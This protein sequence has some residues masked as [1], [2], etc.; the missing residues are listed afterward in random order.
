MAPANTANLTRNTTTDRKTPSRFH[1]FA[2]GARHQTD[3]VFPP[4]H[5]IARAPPGVHSPVARL[6]GARG[7][8]SRAA[9]FRR[10]GRLCDG[11]VDVGGAHVISARARQ[12]VRGS[13]VRNKPDLRAAVARCWKRGRTSAVRVLPPTEDDEA[14]AQAGQ[15][16]SPACA[17]AEGEAAR[18][19]P[20]EPSHRGKPGWLGSSRWSA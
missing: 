11:R 8:S 4:D 15:A 3:V 12:A 18:R 20:C 14:P 6:T 16:R 19:R 13:T 2:P 17:A 7:A 9:S 5:D 10:R 1:Q